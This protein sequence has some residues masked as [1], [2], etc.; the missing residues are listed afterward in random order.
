MQPTR[1]TYL[2]T[3]LALLVL[4]A[5]TLGISFLSLG[6]LGSAAAIAIAT[7]KALLI[8]CFFMHLVEQRASN[9]LALGIAVLLVALFIAIAAGEVAT[10]PEGTWR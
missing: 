9:A 2:W 7:V 5:A 1:A 6:T 8:A 10:R 3:Y 4:S